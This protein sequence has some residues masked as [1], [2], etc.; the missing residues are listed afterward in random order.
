MYIIIISEKY[1]G[2]FMLEGLLGALILAWFLNLFN[3]DNITKEALLE[4]FN[5]SIS[6]S[7]YYFIFAIIGLVGGALKDSKDNHK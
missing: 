3:F 1:G 6:T 7:T 5:I 4:L 2:G